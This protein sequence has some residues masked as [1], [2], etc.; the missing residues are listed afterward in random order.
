MKKY[1]IGLMTIMAAVIL[2]GCTN[3]SAATD[4]KTIN[5]GFYK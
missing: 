2:A 3:S 4:K 5:V 1:L